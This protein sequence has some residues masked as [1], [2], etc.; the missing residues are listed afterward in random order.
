MRETD[1]PLELV[2]GHREMRGPS[3][4]Y[5]KTGREKRATVGN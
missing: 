4:L 5:K 1:P 3:F 2:R